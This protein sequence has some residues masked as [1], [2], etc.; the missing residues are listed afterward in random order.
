[1][2]QS[3]KEDTSFSN[4]LTELMEWRKQAGTFGN[5][6]SGVDAGIKR[7]QMDIDGLEELFPEVIKEAAIENA[8]MRTR[9]CSS[10]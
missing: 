1:M 4:M 6:K 2:L 10:P 3:L 7:A 8:S 9:D 5:A